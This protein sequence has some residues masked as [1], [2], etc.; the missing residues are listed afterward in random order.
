MRYREII[1]TLPWI[2]PAFLARLHQHAAVL[3]LKSG[4]ITPARRAATP[5]VVTCTGLSREH[6]GDELFERQFHHRRV[7]CKQQCPGD[8]EIEPIR[9]D[10]M[11]LIGYDFR[12]VQQGD[13][14]LFKI[15]FC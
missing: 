9:N 1:T 12:F 8:Y 3:G 5:N 6:L 2:P 4:F 10:R 11:V 13:A 7:W 15:Y 14:A